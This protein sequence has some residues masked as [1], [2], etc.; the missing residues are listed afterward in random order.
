MLALMIVVAVLFSLR[1][2]F[3]FVVVAKGKTTMPAKSTNYTSSVIIYTTLA[4]FTIYA[5]LN[6]I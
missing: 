6:W 2:V 3:S 5:I 4:V 1:A